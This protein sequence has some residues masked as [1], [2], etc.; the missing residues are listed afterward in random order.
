MDAFLSSPGSGNAVTPV[1]SRAPIVISSAQVEQLRADYTRQTG[2]IPSAAEEQRLIEEAIEEEVLYREA[3][4]RGLHRGDRS[5]RYRLIQKMRFVANDE[6]ADDE[7]LYRQALEMDLGREDLVIRRVLTN[8]IRFVMKLSSGV[9]EPTDEE[10]QA[11]L[12]ENRDRY[13][14]PARISFSHV[15]LSA[16]KRGESLLSDA[17]SVLREIR[18]DSVRGE[19][20]ISLGDPFAPGHEFGPRSAQAL[21]KTFGSGFARKVFELEPGGWSDPVPSA[22]GLHLVRVEEITPERLPPLESVRTRVAGALKYEER[23]RRFREMVAELV[24]QY[25][26]T[27]EGATGPSG[28]RPS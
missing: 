20:A 18:A 22:Y 13:L 11:Y 4:A 25:E 10:L 7:Q 19:P 21:E 23:E 6:E 17:R 28:Q 16:E 2:M 9:G 3:L 8:K 1:A 24:K 26:V 5:I 27:V 15:F 14:Q 12:E